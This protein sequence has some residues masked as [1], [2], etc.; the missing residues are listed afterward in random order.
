MPAVLRRFDFLVIPVG[1]FH[2]ADGEARAA[3]PAPIDQIA[4]I[5]LGV[6]QVGLNDDAGVR[7]IR[8]FRLGEERFEKFERGVFVRVT[9]H[10]E[11]D[12]GADLARAAQDRAQLRREMRDRVL[13]VG[14]I[15][16]RIERRDFHGDDSRPE[17][18]RRSWPS[19]SVQPR[20]SPRQAFEQF[21]TTR[22]VFV[23]FLFA[24]DRFAEE[25]DGEADSFLA[26]FA[27]RLHD[28][29]RISSG[30]ELPRHAG[31]VPA[32]ERRR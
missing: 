23:R 30:D 29:L 27:Q 14:R 12:E 3:L 18:A 19:G 4:Q 11:I 7:P 26:P 28:V 16:L 10:V 5:A 9:L 2:Q 15:H 20:V 31:N 13:R 25:I 17:K 32:Q 24:H 8:E 22:G 21:E 6:A 1:A